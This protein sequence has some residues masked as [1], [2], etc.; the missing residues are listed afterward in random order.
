MKPHAQI[1]GRIFCCLFMDEKTEATR[2]E[3]VESRAEPRPDAKAAF[4]PVPHTVHTSF[5]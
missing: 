1:W 2:V 4:S 5:L 3:G